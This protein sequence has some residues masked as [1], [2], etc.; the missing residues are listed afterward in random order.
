MN[1]FNLVEEL[2]DYLSKY[3][4][5]IQAEALAK[6]LFIELGKDKIITN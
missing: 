4:G 2:I 3:T 6:R 5:T 1:N